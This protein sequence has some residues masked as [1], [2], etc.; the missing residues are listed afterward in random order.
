M[1]NRLLKFMYSSTKE[2]FYFIEWLIRYILHFKKFSRIPKIEDSVI[3]LGN[4][5]SIKT[6]DMDKAIKNGYQFLAVNFYALFNADFLEIRPKYYCIVDPAFYNLRQRENDENIV[7][8]E[9]ILEKVN[10][11]MTLIII[12][13]QTPIF[14]NKNIKLV[15]LN[16]VL[17]RGNIESIRNF[18]YMNNLGS[19]IFQNVVNAAIYYLITARA[20]QI[21]LVGVENDW[22]RELFVDSKNEVYRELRHFYGN[23]RIN[24]TELGEIKKGELF[25]YFYWYYLTLLSHSAASLY[26]RSIGVQIVNCTPDSYID[27]YDKEDWNTII[28]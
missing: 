18:L 14:R 12:E 21:I 27:V 5:P 24:I 22:H 2:L 28:G 23:K 19:Y 7:A 8:L 6:L 16:S 11:E 25:R 9:L 20:R 13:G 1:K 10:W 3:V 15:K 17:Y 4:G 26:A